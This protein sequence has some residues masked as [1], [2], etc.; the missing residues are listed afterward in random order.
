LKGVIVISYEA[1]GSFSNTES[2]L[3]A[4]EHLAVVQMMED[5]GREG[6]K[7]LAYAT[8]HDTG[9]A[10]ISWGYEVSA[11][12]GFYT[13]T[14]INTDIENGFPVVIALQYGHGTGTGGYVKGR[15]F[16]NPAIKP[17]FDSI[18]N[19]LWKAVTSA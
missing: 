4:M 2:F 3:K 10:S 15:D 19:R 16:I 11:S 17:I 7:A 13:V 14:W 5:A 12:N 9:L 1:T 6:V 18:A 8:P